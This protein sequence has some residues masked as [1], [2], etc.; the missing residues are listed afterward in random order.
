MSDIA[1]QIITWQLSVGNLIEIGMI[2]IGLVTIVNRLQSQILIIRNE[3]A[4]LQTSMKSLA[5]AFK[6]LGTVLT[7]VA[8]QDTRL[9]MIEK[10]VD[11]L[12]HGQ[13]FIKN[14]AET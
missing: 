3:V 4:H 2:G 13:G 9:N 8:V 7:Q 14:G 1:G 10:R 5:E 12:S 11:E 6:Q